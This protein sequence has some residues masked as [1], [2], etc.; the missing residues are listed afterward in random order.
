MRNKM[1]VRMIYTAVMAALVF[2]ATYTIRIPIP[3]TSGYINLG[4]GMV[5]LSGILLGPMYGAFAAG[6]GSALSDMIGGYAFWV[7]PTL[8]IKGLMAYVVGTLTSSPQFAKRKIRLFSILW[9]LFTGILL[10]LNRLS[11]FVNH[12]FESTLNGLQEDSTTPISSDMAI[13]QINGLSPILLALMI[14][15]PIVL[16]L[17]YFIHKRYLHH[18]L[19]FHHVF[20]YFLGGVIMIAGY[21]L[22]YAILAGNFMVPIFSVPANTIQATGGF[23]VATLLTPS[24]ERIRRTIG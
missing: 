2:I 8:L 10:M 16:L 6:L 24:F 13:E 3:A 15:V 20:A 14:G 22:T 12:L 9:I 17:L 11:L 19:T 7:L 5:F 1:I 21:Y 4:D 18:R 23:I